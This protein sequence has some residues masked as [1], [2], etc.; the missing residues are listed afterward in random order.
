M[1]RSTNLMEPKTLEIER[2]VSSIIKLKR[3]AIHIQDRSKIRKH[4]LHPS[5]RSQKVQVEKPAK[6]LNLI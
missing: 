4:S 6:Q 3:P 5:D 2:E 1:D